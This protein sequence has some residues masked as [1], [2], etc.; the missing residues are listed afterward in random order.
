MN[1]G[2]G[3]Q[4]LLQVWKSTR[5]QR[6]CRRTLTT[7]APPSRRP[8]HLASDDNF[9]LITI[10]SPTWKPSPTTH[11][12]SS[13]SSDR[14]YCFRPGRANTNLTL[15]MQGGGDL[16]TFA[17]RGYVATSFCVLGLGR[18]VGAVRV[19]CCYSLSHTPLF[20]STWLSGIS[21]RSLVRLDP[22]SF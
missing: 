2:G 16:V 22:H 9:W 13:P 21:I 1:G 7:F 12:S 8:F 11:F 17:S 3:L 15:G 6:W 4:T 19:R 5:P 18:G 20:F 10:S 14:V